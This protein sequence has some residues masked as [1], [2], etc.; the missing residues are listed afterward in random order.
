MH[1]STK[2]RQVEL[3][4]L[5]MAHRCQNNLFRKKILNGEGGGTIEE[6]FSIFFN[7]T[8]YLLMIINGSTTNFKLKRNKKMSLKGGKGMV[9]GQ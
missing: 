2:T 4:I 8:P 6:I 3:N 5:I 9:D 1:F 7:L